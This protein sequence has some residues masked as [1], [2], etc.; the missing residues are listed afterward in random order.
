MYHYS[1]L[2]ISMKDT[3]S[4]LQKRDCFS[5]TIPISHICMLDEDAYEKPIG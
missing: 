3:P 4:A 2:N 1:L 5:H